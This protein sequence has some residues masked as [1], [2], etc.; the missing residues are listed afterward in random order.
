ML[1]GFA[2]SVADAT[3]A[4]TSLASCAGLAGRGTFAARLAR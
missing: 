1:E 4:G 3:T 2:T